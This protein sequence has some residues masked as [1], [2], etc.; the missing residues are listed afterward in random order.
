MPIDLRS[1]T[2]TR[3]TP[4]MRRAMADAEVGDDLWGEDP[5]VN[6]LQDKA[7][8]L[9]G[10]EAALYVPTGT[11]ANEIAIRLLSRPGQ[12]V[13]ADERSHVIE[14]E[15]AG[16]AALS[17][18]MPMP[19]RTADGRLTPALLRGAAKPPGVNRPDVGMVVL[20]NTHN[21]AGGTVATVAE[22]QAAI[23]AARELGWKVHVDGARLWNAAI[24]LGCEPRELVAGADTAMVALSKGL[25]CP[26]GS[27][28]LST[29]DRIREARRIRSLFGGGWRQAGVVAAAGLVALDTMIQ[30]LAD[31]HANARLL[32]QA[33][34]ACPGALTVVPQTNIVVAQ[35]PAGAAEAAAKL[36]AREVLAAAM[37]RTTL[38]LVTHHDVSR[39]DCE[40]A[41]SA[42][43]EVLA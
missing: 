20:E 12:L 22:M 42:I 21:L 8:A 31:D 11:M 17:G 2:M 35:V 40:A 23:A 30:R 19:I 38:R 3:P 15:L 18:A 34:G 16:M 24:A 5:T 9:L 37:D 36:L 26:I 41:A 10:F 39:A 13:V 6:R 29:A 27:L 32:A 4:A 7:A 43:R 28:L 14:Y 25:C 33:L 1:D